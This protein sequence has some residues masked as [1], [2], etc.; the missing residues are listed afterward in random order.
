[1][2]ELTPQELHKLRNDVIALEAAAALAYDHIY[3]RNPIDET[4]TCHSGEARN[5]IAHA[6][7][8]ITPLYIVSPDRTEFKRVAIHDLRGGH[9]REAGAIM[10][11]ADG[12]QDLS[13]L[14]IQSSALSEIIAHLKQLPVLLKELAKE[15]SAR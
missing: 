1:M 14:C 13:G 10:Q 15:Y 11:F 6:I 2:T 3:N 12:R 9:F 8:S 4:P 7:T 5:A